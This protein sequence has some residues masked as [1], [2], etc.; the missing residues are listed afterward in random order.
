MNCFI[1]FFC[2]CLT[3]FI[4]VVLHMHLTLQYLVSSEFVKIMKTMS[5]MS[6][7]F[8]S[9][10]DLWKPLEKARIRKV[11]GKRQKQ[12][13]SGFLLPRFVTPRGGNL[14]IHCMIREH[15]KYLMMCCVQC[16]PLK[17]NIGQQNAN[18][19]TLSSFS[20]WYVSFLF[21]FIWFLYVQGYLACKMN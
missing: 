7:T 21:H 18:I 4:L 6:H 5:Q 20:K 17:S 15:C 12:N 9:V 13:F 1:I 16:R 8:S 14:R 3:G 2:N 19:W 10:K 11:Y